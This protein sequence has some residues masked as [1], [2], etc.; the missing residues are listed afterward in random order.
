MLRDDTLFELAGALPDPEIPVLT[1]ADL[2]IV[3]DAF[4]EAGHAVVVLTPTYSGCPATEAIMTDVRDTLTRSGYPSAEVRIA[5]SPAWSS[6]WI[7]ADGRRKLRDYGIAPPACAN[8]A[9]GASD[10]SGTPAAPA[11]A[12]SAACRGAAQPVKW[13]ARAAI[14]GRAGRADRAGQAGANTRAVARGGLDPQPDC[15]RC[16]SPDVEPISLWGSTP[17]KALYRCRACAE[18]FDYFKPY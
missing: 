18:P 16:G 6:D 2:G 3:R 9:N 8:G 14:A 12:A 13:H 15:P 1:L 4:V 5:L 7:S 17:C 10:A 11:P